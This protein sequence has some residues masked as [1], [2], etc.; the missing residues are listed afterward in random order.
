VFSV[1]S[2][3]RARRLCSYHSPREDNSC[4]AKVVSVKFVARP[5]LSAVL[6]ETRKQAVNLSV[7]QD[8]GRPSSGIPEILETEASIAKILM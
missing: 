7:H 2:A 4:L 8:G 1:G 5:R 3:P 6:F